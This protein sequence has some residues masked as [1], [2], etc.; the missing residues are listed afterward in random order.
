MKDV[1]RAAT[2]GVGVY[3]ACAKCDALVYIVPYV[4]VYAF[5]MAAKYAD[6]V[7]PSGTEHCTSCKIVLKKCKGARKDQSRSSCG[8]FDVL[9]VRHMRIQD[10]TMAG[11][12]AIESCPSLSAKKKAAA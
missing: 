8:I 1:I 7:G 12:S 4:G 11:R 6:A 10:R 3:D 9:D 5:P 2:D